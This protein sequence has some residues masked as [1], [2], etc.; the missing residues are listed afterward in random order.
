MKLSKEILA[1]KITINGR[2]LIIKQNTIDPCVFQVCD[3]HEGGNVRGILL[4]HVDDIML[5]T[6]KDLV[7][8]I[9][10]ALQEK[11]P[12]EEWVADEFEYVGCEYKMYSY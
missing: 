3:T 10:K 4:T 2:T 12:V 9:Q 6:E 1:I 11:F 7:E 5:M 8:P